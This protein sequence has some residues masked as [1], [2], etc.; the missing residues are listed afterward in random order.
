MESALTAV[1]GVWAVA[2]RAYAEAGADL[3]QVGV[4]HAIDLPAFIHFHQI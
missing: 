4:P 1:A 2:G 3:S